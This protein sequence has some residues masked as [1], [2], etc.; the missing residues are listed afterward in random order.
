MPAIFLP[1]RPPAGA[2]GLAEGAGSGA[3][4][5]TGLASVA[6]NGTLN[7]AGAA[8]AAISTLG[9]TVV[10]TRRFHPPVAG[11]FFAAISLF[12]IVEAVANLGAYNGAIYFIARLQALNAERRIPAILRATIFPVLVSSIG[13]AV[14][15]IVFA[16]PLA[17]LLLGG[18]LATGVSAAAVA[19]ALRALAVALPF[20]A[21]ADTLLGASRGYRQM[22]PTVLVDRIGRSTLQLLGVLAAATI[23]GAAW[24]APLWAMPYI[25][26]CVV[27]LFWLRRIRRSQPG[28][29]G[30]ARS[31]SGSQARPALPP[32]ADPSAG[33]TRHGKPNARGLWRFTAPRSLASGAQIIIQR[34]DIVLVGILRGP[35]DAA[36]YTA[37]TRFLVAGQL[38]NAAISM[39]AQPQFTRLFAVRDWRGAKTVYQATT[40]WLI[41]LTWPLYLL[42]IAYGPSVLEIFGHS[43]P[44]GST[45][46]IILGLAMLVATGCGQVDMVLITA[47]RSGWSLANGLVAMAINIGVDLALIPRLGIT[48]AA[49]GWAAAIAVTNLVPLAQVAVTFR[50]H[51][52]GRGNLAACLLAAVSFG[53]IPL[54][55]RAL[56]GSGWVAS[57]IAVAAGCLLMTAGVWLLRGRLQLSVLPRL[58]RLR[59]RSADPAERAGRRGG[60]HR[61]ASC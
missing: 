18:R 27:A 31:A 61:R 32:A 9:V 8:V 14:A 35:V 21:L 44:A 28:W 7:L 20:A 15:L 26:A 13:S 40:G 55:L 30:L 34:L 16:E 43:Y 4:D 46:M 24:L 42:A 59:R 41:L 51:P 25:P 52:F 29:L 12:L 5:G 53:A 49:I 11:A 22:R 1:D 2:G 57:T 6:R 58:G 60:I 50:L 38:G 48:G 19:S 37:A 54:G 47:G 10:V 3:E 36:V 56:A 23:G 33:D 17:R 39:A 45:V